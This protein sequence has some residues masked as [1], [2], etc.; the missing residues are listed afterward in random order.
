MRLASVE[1]AARARQVSKADPAR[2]LTP[3]GA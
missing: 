3:V 2:S 1:T